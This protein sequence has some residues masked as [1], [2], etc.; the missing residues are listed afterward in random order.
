MAAA[1]GVEAVGRCLEESSDSEPEQE[2]GSPQKLIRK[3][4]TSGQIRSKTI[5]KEGKLMK[6]TNSFQR[7]KRRY[8]KLRGRTLYYAQTAKS[9][10]FDEVDLTDASVAESST[11]NI[12]NSFTIITP[13]RKLILCAENRKEMEDWIAAVRS[14]QNREHF[15]STQYSMDHFSG[16]HNWYACSH[17]RPTY[18]N[19]CREALSGVT[20]HGLSC[21]V[22]KF[23]AHKRCAVRATNNCKWTTLASIGKDII[24]DE[25]GISMPHQWLEGNLPVSAKCSVCDKTC[26]SVLRLQDW[27]CL[28]CKAMVHSVCKEQLSSK[29]PLGQCKVSVIPPTALN[30]IDSDG[31]WKASCPPSCTSPLL[32]FVNS[33]SGD[34]QGVKFLR[35]FKQLLNPAQV[36]DLMNG[37]PHLGLRLFQKFDTFRI[38]VCGGDGSVG[39]VLSEIDTLTLHK[40]CQLGVLPLGTGNDLARVLGW[41]SACDDDTQL[42]QILEK[43]ER[44]STKMLDRWSIMVY[45]TKFPRQHSSS[46]VTEDC[47]DDSEVQQILT[48]EDSVAAHLSKILTSDQHSVVISSAKVLCETVKDFVARVGKAYEKTPESSEESETMA[49]KCGVLKEKLD[50]LLKTLNEEAQA[51]TVLSTPPPTI[52]EE[53]EEGEG[54][55]VPPHSTPPAP[56]SP[57]ATSAIFKP[58]E[59][60]M[61]RANSLKKAIRQIIEH[62][63]KAV[64]EQNAQTQEQIFALA[65]EEEVVEEEEEDD[66]ECRVEDKLSLQSSY[67]G[68]A[69]GHPARRAS[70]SPCEKLIRKGSLPLGSSASLPVQTG[71]RDNMPMLNTK[72]LYPSLRAGMSGSLST[73]SVISRL[74]VNADPFNCDPENLDCYTEK[75]VMNNYFGIG[76]D[77]KISLDFNN[78]RDEH[79]EKCRSRTKN[80][81][82]YGVL[83]TKELLHRT[84][85]NLEQRVLLECD[86]RPIPLPSLQG[87]AV[88]N[89]PSY[90]G[91]TNFWGGTKEDDTF[92]APSFDDKVLE[93]V[94]VFGS[95]Q[96]AVSR[97]INLQHHRIAQCRTV[98]I[99]ILGDEGVP[100]QVDGE[101]WIQ[102]PGYIRII[103]KN[104]TQTLTRD[105]AFENTLKSWEDKQKC[106]FPRPSSQHALQPETVSEEEA[107][108]I[109]LF[110]QAAGA[111]IHSIREI[112]QSQPS[113]EQ[114]LAHA[115]NASSKAMDVVYAKNTEQSLNCSVVVQ[116]VSNVKALHNET[117]LLLAGKMCLLDPPQKEQLSDAL[118]SVGVQLRRLADI[119][120]LCQLI[121]PSDDEVHLVDFSKRNRSAKFRLVP[122]FKKDKNNKN[123]ETSAS[124]GL[125]VHQWGIEEVAAWLELICLTEY[126]E[127]FISHDVR[128]A[129][130]LQ[131]ERRDLKDLG[132]TK[133]GHMKRILQG[134]RELSRNSSASEA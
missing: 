40:Q 20:S 84:Y 60:L 71:S 29:C 9:I 107:A 4:S 131:L 104:R 108:Q 96:M 6:Q 7:W 101:A 10:I 115:V 5:L 25:D 39:W 61:L 93:V 18:C 73:S 16:M 28:W 70:K 48:Y 22:C 42:P 46:T 77:A 1:A 69:K 45:E 62:T 3:V 134:I 23:K 11:K 99:T 17:A 123:K 57:R 37:G 34:N 120:W 98:K 95:M 32:V 55:L 53:Q 76:L 33:K 124:L 63:E 27:R 31:F 59:Q 102:P 74:L 85:R 79:P 80:R 15:E 51:S 78:K 113:L 119:A 82:C 49:K 64:D 14:V 54:V 56:C 117:E 13:C 83:A 116:M 50:S 105:R 26:G 106:E 24:E 121:E 122:K 112:A 110:G 100:V 126:K 132:V 109:N 52:E 128:G 8:F 92:T 103:H 87:I 81:M 19:V 30:S 67:S 68:N 38:L 35:R 97:V 72:I 75:C 12:N 125:P 118:G 127:I 89:I 65:P 88:L 36:F 129:E 43:L 44:A 114:E 90:A 91:G 47:S 66:E 133:V 86:G 21:E 2:P 130:L 94:A 41:G 111:L 58:R